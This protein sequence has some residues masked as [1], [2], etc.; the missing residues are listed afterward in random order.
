M[1]GLVHFTS[2]DSARSPGWVRSS[3]M[4]PLGET[5]GEIC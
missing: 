2:L 5:F 1:T 4:T 3:P